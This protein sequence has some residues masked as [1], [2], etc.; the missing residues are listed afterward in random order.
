M[1]ASDIKQNSV[2]Y[3]LCNVS[4]ALA[5]YDSETDKYTYSTPKKLPGAVSMTLSAVGQMDTFYAD[6]IAYY[7]TETNG[8]YEGD[9][10]LANLPNDFRTDILGE[11]FD[12]NGMLLESSEAVKKEFALLFQFEGDVTQKKHVLYRCAASRPEISSSTKEDKA[13]YNKR[14]LSITSMARKNDKFIKGEAAQGSTNYA[15]F[16]NSVQEPSFAG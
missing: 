2:E 6:N 9:I 13:T 11:V 3:G 1:P 16:F 12:D 5:T 7:T 10:E 4:Y 15:T 8:G 14:K